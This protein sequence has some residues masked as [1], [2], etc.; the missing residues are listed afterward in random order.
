[1]SS[2]DMVRVV[3]QMNDP[4]NIQYS[5]QGPHVIPVTGFDVGTSLLCFCLF[6]N[7][8]PDLQVDYPH[9]LQ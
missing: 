8:K 7:F 9:A 2:T 5:L 1:M 6:P 4:D 3:N